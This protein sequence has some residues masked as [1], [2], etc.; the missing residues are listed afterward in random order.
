MQASGLH[1]TNQP[2][3]FGD[4]DP[5]ARRRL[6]VAK[7]FTR[8]DEQGTPHCHVFDQ[9]PIHV[10][11]A[12]EIP[13]GHALDTSMRG[14]EDCRG[15]RAVKA[16]HAAGGFDDVRGAVLWR[17]AMTAGEARPAFRGGELSH[18]EPIRK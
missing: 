18:A 8:E 15:I 2:P 16:D 14:E 12:L 3:P 6:R 9:R 1:V 10:K 11:G 5:V 17:N 13:D 4:G 7:P